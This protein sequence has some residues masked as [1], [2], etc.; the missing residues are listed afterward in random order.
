MNLR[1]FIKCLNLRNQ[2]GNVTSVVNVGKKLL[3]YVCESEG[4]SC[5]EIEST[6]LIHSI[7]V[8]VF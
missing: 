6:E 8:E 1:G 5:R 3:H 7:A 2:V 4:H